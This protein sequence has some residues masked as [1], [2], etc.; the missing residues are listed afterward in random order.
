MSIASAKSFSKVV[1]K[2]FKPLLFYSGTL[3]RLLNKSG[4]VRLELAVKNSNSATCS[5]DY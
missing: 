3:Y 1:L 2:R 4:V 5:A